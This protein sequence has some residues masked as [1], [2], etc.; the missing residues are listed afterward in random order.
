MALVLPGLASAQ[1]RGRG[2]DRDHQ[3]ERTEQQA[4]RQ[5]DSRQQR[6]AQDRRQQVRDAWIPPRPSMYRP[7]REERERQRFEAPRVQRENNRW[8]MPVYTRQDFHQDRVWQYGRFMRGTGP[9]YVW[10]LRGGNRARF[11]VSGVS[12]SLLAADYRWADDWM[13][14][15]DYIVVYVDPDH[16]GWYLAYN[17]RLGMYLHVRYMGYY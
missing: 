6:E 8:V 4:R 5:E 3:R 17:V 1:G 16:Y 9:R 11:N 10:Q 12:F 15:R 2:Q 7:S 13:W 14:D